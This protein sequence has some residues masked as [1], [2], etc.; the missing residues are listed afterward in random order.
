MSAHSL[1]GG[2]N[3]RPLFQGG[4]NVRPLFSGRCTN[5][6]HL[7]LGRGKYPVENVRGTKII[8]N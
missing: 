4:A 8:Q 2:A 7:V 6:L 3:V 1:P 5:V